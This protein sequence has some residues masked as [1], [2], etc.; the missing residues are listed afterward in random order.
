MIYKVK[1][2]RIETT[3]KISSLSCLGDAYRYINQSDAKPEIRDWL[4]RIHEDMLA[5]VSDHQL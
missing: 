5:A 2:G 1:G 4:I 3:D